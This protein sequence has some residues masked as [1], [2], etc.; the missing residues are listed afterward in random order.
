MGTVTL[1]MNSTRYVLC[2]QLGFISSRGAAM[3]GHSQGSYINDML[4][5]A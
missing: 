1:S 3:F 2:V 4:L 5:Y